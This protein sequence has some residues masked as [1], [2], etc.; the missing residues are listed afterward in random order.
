MANIDASHYVPQPPFLFFLRIAQ[1][2]LSLIVLALTAYSMSQLGNYFINGAF[3]YAIFCCIYTFAGVGYLLLAERMFINIWQRYV[4]L[5]LDVFGV[6]FWLSAWGSLAGWAALYDFANHTIYGTDAYNKSRSAY[7]AAWR[8]TAAS[9]ALGA[10][11]WVMY[12]VALVTYSIA[13]HRYRRAARENQQ[14][15][16]PVQVEGKSTH[17]MNNVPV[18][19]QQQQGPYT[20]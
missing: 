20:A 2:V 13:L 1:L 15:G 10:L 4:A 11:V 9:A 14:T 7:L 17:E 5:L 16:V 3:G 8:C 12:F 18:Y 6:I 19:G